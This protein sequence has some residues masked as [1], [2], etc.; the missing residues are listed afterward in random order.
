MLGD[1]PPD[2]QGHRSH[3]NEA[4]EV[5]SIEDLGKLTC[6]S[7]TLLLMDPGLLHFWS[8]AE[9]PTG[10]PV[11]AVVRDLEIVGPDAQ[12]AGEQFDRQPHPLYLFDIPDVEGMARFFADF[13]VERNLRAT[14]RPLDRRMAH[15]ERVRMS[16]TDKSLARVQY[17]GMWAVAVTVPS[18]RALIVRGERMPSGEFEGRWRRF[19]MDLE[20]GESVSEE[21]VE[22]VMVDTARLLIGD[23]D[24]LDRHSLD[25]ETSWGDGIFPVVAERG[26]QGQIL[27]LR[28]ELGDEQRQEMLREVLLSGVEAVLSL[29]VEEGAPIRQAERLEDGHWL[30]ITGEETEEEMAAPDYFGMVE[31]EEVLRRNPEL[32]RFMLQGPGFV[33]R[34]VG[35]EWSGGY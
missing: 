22:G 4:T 3:W 17:V 8:D 35:G 33:A 7:G 15:R 2:E 19:I 10:D 20:V 13:C 23:V 5:D 30:F 29:Q 25:L 18:D 12:R 14:C 34:R 21:R 32:R 26:S 24:S 1:L 16:L 9:E 28:V 11:A 6:S 31:L 27:R